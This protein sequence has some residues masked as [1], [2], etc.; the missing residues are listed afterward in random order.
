MLNEN[1]MSN[2]EL[3]L[4]ARKAEASKLA[5][6]LAEFNLQNHQD[7]IQI[8]LFSEKNLLVWLAGLIGG[9]AKLKPDPALLKHRPSKT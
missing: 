8:M 3:R 2:R 7:N 1:G 9:Q 6:Q 5:Q 4:Q